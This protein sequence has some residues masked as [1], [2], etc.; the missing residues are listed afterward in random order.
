MGN[1]KEQPDIKKKKIHIF[2]S[3]KT[4]KQT[5][6]LQQSRIHIFITHLQDV[7]HKKTLQHFYY[8]QR[9]AVIVLAQIL[10]SFVRSEWRKLK[11][12][13]TISGCSI[14]YTNSAE[15]QKQASWQ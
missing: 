2:F 10:L 11:Q 5:N 3:L 9:Q 12:S 14:A 13:A 7:R 8:T 6:K 4:N 15:Q 1:I